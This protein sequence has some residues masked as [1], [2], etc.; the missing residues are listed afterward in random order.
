MD[1]PTITKGSALVLAVF[2][3]ILSVKGKYASSEVLRCFQWNWGGIR[4]GDDA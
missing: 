1:F 4:G 3:A 2:L